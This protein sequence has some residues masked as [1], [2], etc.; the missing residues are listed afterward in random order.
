MNEEL[1][2]FIIKEL[3]KYQSRKEVVR[4]VC[5]R[6][7]LNWRQAEQWVVFVEV[8]HRRAI[9][10]QHSPSLFFLSVGVLFLGLGLLAFNLETMFAFIQRDVFGQVLSTQSSN[11]LTGLLT[12]LGMTAGGLVGLWK[13]LRTIFPD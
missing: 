10:A 13:G 11:N 3:G 4:K 9:A 7:G 1:T 8:Q 5:E 2:T 6:S 12:G